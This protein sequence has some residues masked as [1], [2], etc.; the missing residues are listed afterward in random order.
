MGPENRQ[1]SIGDAQQQLISSDEEMTG[2]GEV[3]VG[4]QWEPLSLL[5]AL[6]APAKYTFQY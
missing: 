2:E 1:E 5:R 4:T 6:P 3:L